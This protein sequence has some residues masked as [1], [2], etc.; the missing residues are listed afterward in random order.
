VR[1]SPPVDI[2]RSPRVPARVLAALGR[3][4]VSWPAILCAWLLPAALAAAQP[5]PVIAAAVDGDDDVTRSVLVGLAGQVYEPAAP[6]TWQRRFAGGIAP[7]VVGA[8]RVNG[9]LFAHGTDAPIFRLHD[10]VWHAQ[11]LPNRGRATLG[12]GGAGALGLGRHVYTWRDGVWTR[13][14]TIQGTITAVWAANPTRAHV[15][16]AQGALWRIQGSAATALPEPVTAADPV[17]LLAGQ[18]RALYGITRGGAVLR[19]GDRATL[20]GKAPELARWIPQVAATDA[21]GALWALGWIPATD[22]ALA[23][24]V[25]ART[26]G[27]IL[28][29]VE[30][31]PGLAPA[32]RFLV[33]HLDR[34]GGML[35]S[36]TAG[37]V[38]YRTAGAAPPAQAAAG[39]QEARILGELLIPSAAFP[40]RGPAHVR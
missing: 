35:W 40:G 29:A 38:R 4:L 30:T 5:A 20:V 3:G 26:Q 39:W 24:A 23:R 31:L 32:E 21:S 11:P 16:T 2:H 17:V 14:A 19:I 33:L 6:G 22:Q 7:E 13:L 10:T 36:T 27:N 34:R 1:Y 25:L 9:T 15:A 8:A 12:R 18:P 37:I 28:Q